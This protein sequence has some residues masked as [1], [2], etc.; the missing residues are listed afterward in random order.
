MSGT[1][2]GFVVP[3]EIA[4]GECS[5]KGPL[6]GFSVH[7]ANEHPHL[8]FL[9]GGTL[10]STNGSLLPPEKP[11][12]RLIEFHGMGGRPKERCSLC[13]ADCTMRPNLLRLRTNSFVLCN[14]CAW[15][16]HSKAL[17]WEAEYG[18]EAMADA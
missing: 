1:S 16:L 18:A 13:A 7:V 11:K 2:A 9:D 3:G 4:C 6:P 8:R 10:G 12:P 14:G 15:E 5:W 17:A